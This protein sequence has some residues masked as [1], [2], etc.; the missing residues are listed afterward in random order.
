MSIGLDVSA[1]R[2]ETSFLYVSSKNSRF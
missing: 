1:Q 2:N